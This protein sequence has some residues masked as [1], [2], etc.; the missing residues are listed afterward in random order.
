MSRTVRLAERHSQQSIDWMDQAALAGSLACMVHCLVLP[1]IVAALPALS[2]LLAVP[3][4][5]HLW[6]IA[7]AVPAAAFAL[8]AGRARHGTAWPLWLGTTGCVLLLL[9]GVA[10]DEDRWETVVTVV[11]SLALAWAHIA[12]WRLRRVCRHE[13]EGGA[14][15]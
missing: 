6:M 8:V 14:R 3:E 7:L 4:A 5:F 15:F 13:P 9:G 1:L 11:G 12:N 2:S 10:V